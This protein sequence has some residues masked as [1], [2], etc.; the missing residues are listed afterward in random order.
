MVSRRKLLAGCVLAGFGAVALLNPSITLAGEEQPFTAEGFAA[1]KS[2]GKPILVEI[3]ASWCT[4][5]AAQ[6][7][8]LSSLTAQPRFKDLTVLRID[9]DTQRSEVLKLGARVQS[10]LIV[11]KGQTE[12]GRS[13]GDTHLDTIAALLAKAI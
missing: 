5:C 8:I 12:V 6:K 1:A 13:V 2:A 3:H 4:T 11:F 9:F 7:P 10:T